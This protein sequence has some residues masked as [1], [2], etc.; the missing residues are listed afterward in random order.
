MISVWRG[1]WGGG[2]RDAKDFF[3]PRQNPRVLSP[4]PH[5][6]ASRL[7]ICSRKLGNNHT[8]KP[9]PTQPSLSLKTSREQ[10]IL[11]SQASTAT[12][13]LLTKYSYSKIRTHLSQET[14]RWVSTI[15]RNRAEPV[16]TSFETVWSQLL[17]LKLTLQARACHGC[18]E[19]ISFYLF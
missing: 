16:F 6:G 1:G 19:F 15:V 14:V 7:R 9:K 13:D 3:D 4:K 18:F 5:S 11:Q 2:V 10:F 17:V 8:N 12:I